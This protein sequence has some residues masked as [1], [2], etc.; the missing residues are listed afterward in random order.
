MLCAW[1]EGVG[2]GNRIP[3]TLLVNARLGRA[4]NTVRAERSAAGAKSKPRGGIPST[5]PLRGYA[6]GERWVASGGWWVAEARVAT[7]KTLSQPMSPGSVG[8]PVSHLRCEV[9]QLCDD[10]S[11]A[12]GGH[13]TGFQ[14]A[15]FRA[16]GTPC[17]L[18]DLAVVI[19]QVDRWGAQQGQQLR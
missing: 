18:A 5:S 6:Q 4:D 3:S 19:P 10:S 16:A 9:A 15:F 12:A 2:P 7:T 11:W 8:L 1:S 14:Q 13:G 17:S